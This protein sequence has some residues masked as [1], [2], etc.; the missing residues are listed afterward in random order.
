MLRTEKKT[1]MKKKKETFQHSF[2]IV[3]C[4]KKASG[5]FPFRL[6][7]FLFFISWP[8]V[9]KRKKL[10][11]LAARGGWEGF[12]RLPRNFASI[13]AFFSSSWAF[14]VMCCAA[15]RKEARPRAVILGQGK[16]WR[17]LF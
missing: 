6:F 17:E 15:A 11:V 4:T 3:V 13:A 12:N 2:G 14:L 8:L 10:D 5:P 7:G 9:V 16:V 1:H